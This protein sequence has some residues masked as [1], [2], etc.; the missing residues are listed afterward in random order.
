MSQL[1]DGKQKAGPLQIAG[2]ITEVPVVSIT[3]PSSMVHRPRPSLSAKVQTAGL[4]KRY[5]PASRSSTMLPLTPLSVS[6]TKPSDAMATHK[7]TETCRDAYR[8]ST[9][10]N[11]H[12]FF[13][14]LMKTIRL[15]LLDCKYKI[16]ILTTVNSICVGTTMNMTDA[17]SDT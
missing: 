2:R 7:H 4:E 10:S 9:V 13:L 14:A 16:T 12:S 1:Q 11:S 17:L 8:C 3:S 15:L 6:Q 5:L